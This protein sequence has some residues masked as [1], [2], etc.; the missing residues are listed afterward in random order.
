MTNYSK[1]DLPESVKKVNDVKVLNDRPMSSKA[2]K[3]I[4]Q[5]KGIKLSINLFKQKL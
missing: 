4:H 5:N 1:P 3:L 2:S